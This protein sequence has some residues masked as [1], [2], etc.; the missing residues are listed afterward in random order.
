MK[1]LQEN[2]SRSSGGR[3]L[4]W[5]TTTWRDE[6]RLLLIRMWSLEQENTN[7][8]VIIIIKGV[9]GLLTRRTAL[10]C[11]RLTGPVVSPP[12]S[13]ATWCVTAVCLIGHSKCFIYSCMTPC[14]ETDFDTFFSADSFVSAAHVVCLPLG[15]KKVW[16]KRSR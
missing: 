6:N 12:A 10:V 5:V 1:G 11:E 3:A 16:R 8:K 7:S 4:T 13:A 15:L 9:E 2:L 14:C